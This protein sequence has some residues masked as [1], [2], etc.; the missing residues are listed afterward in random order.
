MSKN[1]C[2][3]Y[4]EINQILETNGN[5]DDVSFELEDIGGCLECTENKVCGLW[6]KASFSIQMASQIGLSNNLLRIDDIE[7]E[8]V[9]IAKQL[10]KSQTK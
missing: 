9:N 3:H 4:N 7:N 5:L 2:P 6:V 1:E 8:V 10:C